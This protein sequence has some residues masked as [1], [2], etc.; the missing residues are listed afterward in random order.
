[1][2]CGRRHPAVLGQLIALVQAGPGPCMPA[3]AVMEGRP[4]SSAELTC[5]AEVTTW[6][7]AIATG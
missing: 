3:A 6:Q 5:W 4:S 2:P 7:L 1:M